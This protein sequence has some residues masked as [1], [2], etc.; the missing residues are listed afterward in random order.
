MSNYRPATGYPKALDEATDFILRM[1]NLVEATKAWAKQAAKDAATIRRDATQSGCADVAAYAEMATSDA[2]I[3][4][5]AAKAA[6][7][8]AEVIGRL[9]P[10][11]DP[12]TPSAAAYAAAAKAAF[13]EARAASKRAE[14]HARFAERYCRDSEARINAA[15]SA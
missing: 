3:A 10:P 14:K 6:E 12:C 11:S 13:D 5:I 8:A 9:L 7:G 4:Q 2:T 1:N 15:P